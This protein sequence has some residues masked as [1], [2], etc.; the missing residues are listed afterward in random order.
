MSSSIPSSARWLKRMSVLALLIAGGYFLWSLFHTFV[1]P[2]G[3]SVFS[4]TIFAVV[5]CVL[6]SGI[7][8][9]LAHLIINAHQ[10]EQQTHE[11]EHLL[12]RIAQH[13]PSQSTTV[14]DIP[15]E[16]QHHSMR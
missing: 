12:S 5:V 9:G 14:H 13:T 10:V 3:W 7:T 6:L 11:T 8:Q 16:K 15:Q 4:I 2:A 1:S